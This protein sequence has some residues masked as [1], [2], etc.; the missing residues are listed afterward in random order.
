VRTRPLARAK[1]ALPWVRQARGGGDLAV[2]EV[3]AGRRGWWRARTRCRLRARADGARYLPQHVAAELLSA[4]RSPSR[5]ASAIVL[6]PR[7]GGGLARGLYGHELAEQRRQD[8]PRAALTSGPGAESRLNH[9]VPDPPCSISAACVR[10]LTIRRRCSRAA[11]NDR[12]DTVVGAVD[13]PRSSCPRLTIRSTGLARDAERPG[14]DATVD[15]MVGFE[16]PSGER[17]A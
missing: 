9:P 1:G 5:S 14:S 6:R 8:G 13:G 10:W 15:V 12:F 4:R 2:G 3:R 17:H 11:S 16:P 7:A